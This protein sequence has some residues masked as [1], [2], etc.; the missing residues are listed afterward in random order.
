[1]MNRYKRYFNHF[2]YRIT[3]GC[4]CNLAESAT[5]CIVHGNHV[6]SLQQQRTQSELI[7][8]WLHHTISLMYVGAR[9][10]ESG[11]TYHIVT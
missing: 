11:I 9:Y 7:G 8:Q 6:E 4:A 2:H 5:D 1:M 3:S 10:L